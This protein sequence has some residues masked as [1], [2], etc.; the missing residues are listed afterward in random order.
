M[1][2]TQ[3]PTQKGQ[4]GPHAGKRGS[5]YRPRGIALMM[6]LV[7]V[8]LMTIFITEFFFSS[9]LEMR[10]MQ[11]FK[12]VGQA[13]D[14]ARLAFQAFR[15]S[16]LQDEVEVMK[17]Y[18]EIEK[19]VAA[20]AVPLEDGLLTG[21]SVRPL[22]H[23]Y[24]L[25]ELSGFR[26]GS[27]KEVARIAFFFET[28]K[29]IQLPN[30][31][32]D[33]EPE[34]LD[35]HT[36][37]M[38]F[39]GLVDWIDKDELD[40]L[41]LPGI[42]GGESGAYLSLEPERLVKNGPLDQLREIRGVLAVSES[43]VPWKDLEDRLAVLPDTGDAEL[44]PERLNVN[45]ASREEI[46]AYLNR[47]RIEHLDF[48][49]SSNQQLQEGINNII[50]NAE[51]VA[52]ILVPAENRPRFKTIGDVKTALRGNNIDEKYADHLFSTAN[53]FF[54]VRLRTMVNEVEA[55]LEAVVRV[56]REKR[57]GEA[58]AVE[59]LHLRLE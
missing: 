2:Q 17:G 59:V 22:D 51:S 3:S 48:S 49:G 32:P 13:R 6:T 7:V 11:T 5:R 9:G 54:R 35:Q 45:V 21:F 4:T 46:I 15:F 50:D 10:A 16:L 8:M 53:H 37:G 1:I 52:D 58:S 33:I 40:F 41:R 34:Y 25:N 20:I 39:A 19:A 14:L 42:P 30:E 47:R 43:K 44:I 12:E 27:D 57:T 24:N 29:D 23:L 55:G 28:L 36:I 26:P 31:D 38:M 18:Q 56:K